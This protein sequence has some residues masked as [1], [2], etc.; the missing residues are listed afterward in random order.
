MGAQKFSWELGLVWCVI[1]SWWRG[2]ACSFSQGNFSCIWKLSCMLLLICHQHTHST[3]SAFPCT[4]SLHLRWLDPGRGSHLISFVFAIVDVKRGNW[5][6]QFS[7][8][9]HIYFF[10]TMV[11]FWLS[12]WLSHFFLG[13]FNLIWYV[14]PVKL[15]FIFIFLR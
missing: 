5:D 1:H 12:N 7:V 9:I 2:E 15:L 14:V 3:V 8:Y 11:S 13:D 6:H 4:A 10:I